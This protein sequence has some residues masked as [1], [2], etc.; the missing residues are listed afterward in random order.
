MSE[1]KLTNAEKINFEMAQE[2]QFHR[3]KYMLSLAYAAAKQIR[4]ELKCET[5]GDTKDFT[6]SAKTIAGMELTQIIEKS[7]NNFDATVMVMERLGEI[8]REAKSS[9][10][11]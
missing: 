6:E 7:N 9:A 5:D 3:F 4:G 1:S 11:K 10:G 8:V 2:I